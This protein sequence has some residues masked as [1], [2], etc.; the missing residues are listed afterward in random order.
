L[1]NRKK[2]WLGNRCNP[3]LGT[4]GTLAPVGVKVDLSLKTQIGNE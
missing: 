2:I 1:N 3:L 4:S